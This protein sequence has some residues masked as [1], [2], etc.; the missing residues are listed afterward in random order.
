MSTPSQEEFK[1]RYAIVSK[2][3][4]SQNV[5]GSYKSEKTL[6]FLYE[7]YYSP[8]KNYEDKSHVLL[9]SPGVPLLQQMME[10]GFSYYLLHCFHRGGRTKQIDQFVKKIKESRVVQEKFSAEQIEEVVALVEEI[11]EKRLLKPLLEKYGYSE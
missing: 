10:A 7:S 1:H 11:K 3:L 6:N 4:F 8:E 2:Q 9:L 5:L